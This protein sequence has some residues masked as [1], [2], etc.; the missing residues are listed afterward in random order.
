MA[1]LLLTEK[2]SENNN[3]DDKVSACVTV[4]CA[5]VLADGA[6]LSTGLCVCPPARCCCRAMYFVSICRF[7][8]FF[9]FLFL[10]H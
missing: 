7:V 8:A 6:L 10:L 2:K 9:C 3:D 1:V 5:V 4:R